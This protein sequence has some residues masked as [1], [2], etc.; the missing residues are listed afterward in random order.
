MSVVPRLR[1]P[2]PGHQLMLNPDIC[3]EIEIVNTDYSSFVR[4]GGSFRRVFLRVSLKS[5]VLSILKGK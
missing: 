1:N 5:R 3:K 4:E 2:H